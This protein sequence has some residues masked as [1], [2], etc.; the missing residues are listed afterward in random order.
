MIT[1]TIAAR[2]SEL[3]QQINNC[4]DSGNMTYQY[5]AEM[6]LNEIMKSAP[7][8]EWY[9]FSK[10]G[11]MGNPQ[12]PMGEFDVTRLDHATDVLLIF[13]VSFHHMNIN[14]LY[15]GWTHHRVLV[16]AAF[17]G[18]IMNVTGKDKAHV[19]EY[20]EK[21]FHEWLNREVKVTYQDELGRTTPEPR[22]RPLLIGQDPIRTISPRQLPGK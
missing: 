7:N 12:K 22:R 16:G 13:N 11:D 20:I 15:T 2:L 18:F 10:P 9:G 19:K 8:G 3:K 5:R 17:N 14:G 1:K 4:I 6:E 21:A